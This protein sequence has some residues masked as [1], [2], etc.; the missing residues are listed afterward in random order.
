V[1]CRSS[2]YLC[3]NVNAWN[4]LPEDI[5]N[6]RATTATFKPKLSTIDLSQFA[7]F[8]LFWF[9]LTWNVK[10]P[11]RP[12][13]PLAFHLYTFVLYFVLDLLINDECVFAK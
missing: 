5:V 6:Y 12:H 9:Y 1:N 4:S 2:S 7:I 13:S 8:L 10:S 3:R 11:L